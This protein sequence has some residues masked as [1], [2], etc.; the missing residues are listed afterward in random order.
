MCVISSRPASSDEQVE[1]I[2]RQRHPVTGV[3]EATPLA[4]RVLHAVALQN[5]S[6]V[7]GDTNDAPVQNRKR[8]GHI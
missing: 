7:T 3:A 1:E 2:G 6:N 4:Q 8:L 5:T